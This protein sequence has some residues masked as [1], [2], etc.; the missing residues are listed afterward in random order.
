MLIAMAA[1]S[2]IAFL[3][4]SYYSGRL[5]GYSTLA[6]IRDVWPSLRIAAAIALTMSAA[7]AL[8]SPHP[9]AVLGIQAAVGG[10]AAAAVGLWSRLEAVREF[11]SILLPAVQRRM[12]AGRTRGSG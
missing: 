1:L 3:L 2:L 9:L 7:G 5:I 12:G 11:R 6:Q 8:R 10:L 4:N